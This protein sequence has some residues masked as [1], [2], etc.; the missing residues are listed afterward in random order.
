MNISGRDYLLKPISIMLLAAI[1]IGTN[2]VRL[3]FSNVFSQN[4]KV[5]VEKASL[6]RIPIRLG[7]DVFTTR[8]ISEE[9]IVRLSKTMLAFSILIDVNQPVAFKACATSAMREAKNGREVIDRIFRESGIAIE[10]IDGLEEASLVS[11]FS[12]FRQN[13]HSKYHM[14]IDVGGGSTE[15]SLLKG[16]SII[17]SSSFRIGTVRLL[18][19]K[20]GEKEWDSMRKWLKSHKDKWKSTGLV[21]SGGNINK[22]NKLYGNVSENTL[23]LEQLEYALVHLESHTLQERIHLM[24]LRPD[25]ADVIIHAGRIFRFIMR[26]VKA[27]GIYVPK[28]GLSDGIVHSLYLQLQNKEL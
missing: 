23:S 11:A 28:I 3:F 2:A 5:M 21:G 26:Q 17:S 10:I 7:E 8:R 15:I 9:K 13:Q 25:R 16:S 22:I 20:V 27:T 12:D 4:G 6:V 14:V 19:N 1:D 24:G 18:N